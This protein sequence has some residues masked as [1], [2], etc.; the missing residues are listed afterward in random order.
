VIKRTECRF[1]AVTGCN[2]NLFERHGGAIASRKN[3]RHIGVTFGV[4][5]DF[6]E[7]AQFKSTLQKLG[8]GHQA[9]L[10]KHTF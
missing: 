10:N 9:N 6:T 8:I 5:H 3:A 7:L 4:H 2:H 1:S